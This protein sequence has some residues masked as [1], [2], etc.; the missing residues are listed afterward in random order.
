LKAELLKARSMPGPFLC[1]LAVF[2]TMLIGLAATW[3]WGLGPDLEAYD[4]AIAFP[5]SIA[6][7]I[8]GV[9]LFGVEYG[10]DTMRRTLAADPRRG[11]LVATKLLTGIVLVTIATAVI[12]LVAFPLYDLAAD[13]H[14]QSIE[15]PVYADAALAALVWNVCLMLV[16]SAFAMIA[17]G[18]AGGVTLTLVFVFIVGIVLVAIPEIDRYSFNTALSDI[19]AAIRGGDGSF[20]GVEPVNRALK[21]SLIAA[22]WL[23]VLLGAGALRLLRSDVK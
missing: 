10:Q 23:L 12:F 20:A 15:I 1:A 2:V 9:W 11:R 16:G 14:G 3:R 13:R 5:A 6:S 22:G 4:L 18:M 8:F 17:A 21:A 19:E 7:A